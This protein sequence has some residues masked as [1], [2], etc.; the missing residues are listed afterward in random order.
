MYTSVTGIWQTVWLEPVPEKRIVDFRMVS[1]IDK[2][3]LNLSEETAGSRFL[4]YTAEVM[5][6][7]K[8]VAKVDGKLMA[9]NAIKIPNQ[10]LWSPDNPFLYALKEGE[11]IVDKLIP[12][13]ECVRYLWSK[14]ENF[15]DCSSIMNLSSKWGL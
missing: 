5:E 1:D 4:T 7:D 13:L 11:E 9:P 15:N 6:G 8:V 10:K 3:M 2:S 14:T 12:V